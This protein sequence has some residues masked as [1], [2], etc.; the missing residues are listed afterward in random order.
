MSARVMYTDRVS[1][2]TSTLTASSQAS[3]HPRAN[4][5]DQSRGRTWRSLLGWNV[6]RLFN[7]ELLFTEGAIRRVAYPAPGNYG[8]GALMAAQ[9]QTAMNAAGVDP[10]S[11]GPSAWYRADSLNLADGATLTQW[12]DS[13]GNGLHLN[14]VT[15]TPTL[16]LNVLN[17]R[18][19]VYFD[20]TEA[21][22]RANVNWATLLGA[23]G[24]GTVFSVFR[25]DSDTTLSD[26]VWAQGGGFRY[27]A[28]VAGPTATA[29]FY[30]G[31]SD[32]AN[33]GGATLNTWHITAWRYDG[34]ANGECF[35][36]DQ[37]TAAAATVATG[38]QQQL[39]V[40][41]L[42]VGITGGALG[43]KGH[44]VELI[45]YPVALSEEERRRV[46]A[47]LKA[48]YAL[49]DSTTAPVWSGSG[50][51]GATPTAW[52]KPE[53][54]SA[55]A[56]NATLTS[57]PDSSGNALHLNV[58]AGT[59]KMKR[60]VLGKGAI[61]FD[62]LSGLSR[63]AVD[64]ATLLGA[65]GVGTVLF[66]YRPIT[67]TASGTI[68]YQYMDATNC[69]CSLHI[70]PAHTLRCDFYD[71]GGVDQSTKA[72]ASTLDNWHIG[73]WRYTGGAN[74]ECFCDDQDTAAA[75]TVATGAQ[76]KLGSSTL[77][78]GT[79][80]SLTSL[81]GNIA[82]LIF[83]AT[84]LTE[85]QMRSVTK[86]LKDKYGL[87]DGTTAPTVTTYAAD[88]GVAAAN[89]VRLSRSA[90]NDLFGL[91]WTNTTHVRSIGKDLGFDVT[92]DDSGATA[93][94]AD[95]VAYKSR[96]WLKIDAGSALSFLAGIVLDHNLGA[97]G[98]V[99]LQAHAV[100]NWTAPDV[101]QVLAT[102]STSTR[103][104][105]QFASQTKRWLRLLIEDVTNTAGYSE[106]SVW[107][108]YSYS[109]LSVNYSVD[110]TRIPLQ[111]SSFVAAVNGMV[112]VDERA[113]LW[114]HRLSWL[115]VPAADAAILVGWLKVVPIGKHCTICLDPTGAPAEVLY[116]YLTAPPEVTSD[117]IYTTVAIEFI[118]AAGP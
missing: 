98:T 25:C 33:K 63:A 68:W 84:A 29:K 118:E 14:V 100:D 61:Y 108:A 45:F 26:I 31:T 49:T 78:V 101:S 64:F 102:D 21:I 38:A 89:K 105:A 111:L 67:G 19:A 11:Y 72:G 34:G 27:M 16:A 41:S 92:A 3:G 90:G 70:E 69:R 2:A 15:G 109:S 55:L 47:Y 116:G 48:K 39:G 7:D 93:Y 113:Q 87:S 18:P 36:D 58:V 115:E 60:D 97:S 44:I 52:Y 57:W 8:T 23:S 59:P 17:G 46:T 85:E 66:V 32:T 24:V 1:P 82:E 99:T 51:A 80:A 74:G 20:G 43:L 79:N 94:T 117:G 35:L 6:G 81:F 40:A 9:A 107:R 73:A 5:Q 54:L 65:G 62:S 50:F 75:G 110:Y 53:S 37:D 42:E 114:S 28:I 106:L 91:P 83:F 77:Y 104:V 22:S 88:Y 12:D 10:M 112:G 103:R 30:D 95:T 71:A 56:H 4:V 96:E 86:Y 76:T 13:S